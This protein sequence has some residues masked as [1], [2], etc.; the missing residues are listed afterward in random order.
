MRAS[1]DW[2]ERASLGAG[3]LLLTLDAW[4]AAEKQPSA[5]S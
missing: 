5:P 2:M 3:Q 1:M 4:L